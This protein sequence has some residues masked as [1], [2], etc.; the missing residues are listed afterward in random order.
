[1]SPTWAVSSTASSSTKPSERFVTA[2]VS[3]VLRAI[4][5]SF[6]AIG[7][8]TKRARLTHQRGACSPMPGGCGRPQRRGTEEAWG[9]AGIGGRQVLGGFR[10][11]W[12][13][14]WGP[15]AL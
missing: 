7:R 10:V 12:L 11:I 3:R 8:A 2:D 13:T 14:S 4:A 5:A 9:Y 6:Q 1:M 15:G